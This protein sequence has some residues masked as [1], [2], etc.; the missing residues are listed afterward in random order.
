MKNFLLEVIL[1][2]NFITSCIITILILLLFQSEIIMLFSNDKNDILNMLI[3]LSGTLFGFV[4]TFLSI[5]LIFKTDEK[6]R[7]NEENESKPLIM[8]VNNKSFNEVYYLFIKSSYSLGILLI[9]SLIY[10]FIPETINY[11]FKIIMIYS[12]VGVI[13]LCIVRM[14]LSLY[15]FNG[16]IKLLI[17]DKK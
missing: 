7:K 17:L 8:L 3:S 10:F 2:Y 1:K 5:F 12:I 11:I 9:M 4:L 13:V 15:V 16:L 6:Y 14:F